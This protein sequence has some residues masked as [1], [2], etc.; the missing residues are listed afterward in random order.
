MYSAL[1]IHIYLTLAGNGPS[2]KSVLRN[3]PLHSQVINCFLF[4]VWK[5]LN[6]AVSCE[7][8]RKIPTRFKW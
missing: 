4:L 8:Q 7:M 3:Q 2:E 6:A 5:T 1:S